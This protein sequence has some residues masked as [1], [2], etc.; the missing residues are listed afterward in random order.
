M[1]TTGSFGYKIG[2]KIR[3]MKVHTDADYFWQILVREIYVL[4]KHY[5]SIETLRGAFEHLTD[6]KNKPTQ[7]AIQ[8]CKMFTDIDTLN[9]PVNAD[10]MITWRNLTCYCQHSFITMLESGYIL[11]DGIMN[12]SVVFILDFNTSTV[13]QYR[14]NYQNKMTETDTATIAEIMEFTDMPTKTYTE[15]IAGIKERYDKYVEQSAPIDELIDKI[16]MIIQK[17]REFGGDQNILPKLQALLDETILGKKRFDE[18]YSFF[19]HRLDSL[20]LIN[21]S[22]K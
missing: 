4:M 13:R 22:D 8:K 16:T 12:D 3:L 19:Y 11:N 20:D 21:H 6:A 14:T 7:T 5:G 2:R 18:T 15:I 1:V 10:P 9:N 17:T